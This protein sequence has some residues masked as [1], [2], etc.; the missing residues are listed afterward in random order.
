[1]PADVL[2]PI[3][4]GLTLS[5][6][7]SE[8][9]GHVRF[10]K[11]AG[12][13]LAGFLLMFFFKSFFLSGS[14]AL[15]VF[16]FLSNL[17]IV[18]LLLL[19]G[20]EIDYKK[21]LKQ[22]KESFFLAVFGALIP[23][24]LGFLLMSFLGFDFFVS[25]IT[26]FSLSLTA[27]GVTASV[28]IKKNLLHTRL[29][30]LMLG[31]GI[32]DDIFEVIF[33]SATIFFVNNTFNVL[34]EALVLPLKLFLF[35]LIVILLIKIVPK[36]LFW[37]KFERERL[38]YVSFAVI[39]GLWIAFISNFLE[40]G[41]ILGAFIAGFILKLSIRSHKIEEY[42]SDNLKLISFVLVVP[43]FFMYIGMQFDFF[44]FFE[45][46]LLFLL[47]LIISIIGKL[48]A[49]LMLKPF[50]DYSWDQLMLVGW[51]IN[52]RGA[53]ELVIAS[54]ALTATTG[55]P[56]E[57]FSAIVF[58]AVFTTIFFPFALDFYLKKNPRIME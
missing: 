29:S 10:P 51:G 28:L 53:V 2:L 48:L 16:V 9:F 20:M 55:F 39:F 52:S 24:V 30:N 6:V 31:A 3:V 22:S 15:N 5:F 21:M 56:R 58:M 4:V 34:S 47:V 49:A 12:H 17:G 1:M 35:V 23:F 18:F 27:E 46:P 32:I 45:D 41:M 14:D 57:V 33:L 54:I 38:D 11:I 50:T 19:T 25:I 43:F 42:I 13:I 8:F 37:F 40:F 26:G 7:F 44:S 36:I